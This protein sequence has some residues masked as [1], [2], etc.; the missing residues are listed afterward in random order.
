MKDL[1]NRIDE[2]RI[3]GIAKEIERFN[4][5]VQEMRSKK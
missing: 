1:V 5:Q 2:E 4:R 3:K